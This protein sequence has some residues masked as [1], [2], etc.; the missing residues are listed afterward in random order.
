MTAHGGEGQMHGLRQLPRPM[1]PLAQQVDH[2]P[3]RR[4]GKGGERTIDFGCAH[5]SLS[6]LNP[7]AF[8]ISSFETFRTGCEKLQ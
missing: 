6:N 5:V 7:V 4:I 8:S 2:A 1:R 3:A